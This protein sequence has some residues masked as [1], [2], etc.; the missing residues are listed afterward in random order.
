VEDS[1]FASLLLPIAVALIVFSL[2]LSL[3][4]TDFK[5][6]VVSP[7]GVL[8]GLGN[9][10]V[11]SP[12]LAFGVA[13]AFSLEAGLAVGLV[14]L[15]ASPGGA[16]ANMLTHLARGRVALS[17][18]MTAISS[19]AAVITVPLFLGLAIEHFGASSLTSDV[20]MTGVVI[21]VFLITVVPITI[22]MTIRARRP[23]WVAE[24]EPT[25][26]KLA[27]GAFFIIVAGA[28]IAEWEIVVD[29]LAEVAAAAI[30][31]N[32]AAM[33]VSYT[34]ARAARLDDASA[35]AIAMELGVH[36]S[37][38]TIAVGASIATVLTIPAAVYSTF[39][40]VTAGAFARIM[41]R[42]NTAAEDRA[43]R[44]AA[45]ELPQRRLDGVLERT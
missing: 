39:M 29:N 38:L 30:A 18:T 40:F 9:L 44:I 2:G 6:V 43:A 31:L 45:A 5:R 36:N 28:V 33:T 12:L 35:T 7:K 23:E 42:R 21:R 15:G 27:L 8:I 17:V 32:V 37:T 11:L 34:I 20:S 10:I 14:L 24:H 13:E 4:P 19:V 26:K 3:T 22:A 41:Y 1:V 25:V 16:M